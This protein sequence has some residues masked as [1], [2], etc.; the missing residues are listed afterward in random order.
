MKVLRDIFPP[1]EKNG[2]PEDVSKGSIEQPGNTKKDKGE[3]DIEAIKGNS[4]KSTWT[5]GRSYCPQMM[6][7]KSD[8]DSHTTTMC[9]SI[10]PCLTL[11]AHTYVVQFLKRGSSS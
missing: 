11:N 9:T 1:L 3:T 5:I 4:K 6:R 7:M 10:W 8:R 2:E